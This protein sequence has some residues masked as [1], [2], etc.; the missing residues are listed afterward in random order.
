VVLVE[1]E[2]GTLVVFSGVVVI[3]VL[4]VVARSV[5]RS[6]TR[7]VS[8]VVESTASDNGKV[9]VV[10]LVATVES[11]GASSTIGNSAQVRAGSN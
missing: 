9:V 8:T 4:V 10:E 5:A 7:V 11:V 2:L 6:V 1:E 3:V